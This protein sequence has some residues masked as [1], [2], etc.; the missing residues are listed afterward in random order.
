MIIATK[1]HERSPWVAEE[2]ERGEWV[3]V[4]ADVALKKEFRKKRKAHYDLRAFD[5]L[6]EDGTGKNVQV[7]DMA[8]TQGIP[9]IM[10]G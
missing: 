9:L 4:V 8:L 3:V 10:K 2:Q 5:D 6:R 1:K 7:Y